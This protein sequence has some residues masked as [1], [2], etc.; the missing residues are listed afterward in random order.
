MK[1]EK[2]GIINIFGNNRN[3]P[4]FKYLQQEVTA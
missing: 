2:E 4:M 1:L 3:K